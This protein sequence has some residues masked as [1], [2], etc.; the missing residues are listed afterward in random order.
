VSKRD[1]LLPY[2][3]G[4]VL[5][6]SAVLAGGGGVLY[7]VDPDWSSEPN[8]VAAA[9]ALAFGQFAGSVC[10]ADLGISGFNIRFRRR[11]CD[12][13]FHKRRAVIGALAFG[14]FGC[15]SVTAL[16]LSG[17][18]RGEAIAFGMIA[19]VMLGALFGFAASKVFAVVVGVEPPGRP[20]AS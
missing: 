9:A 5:L 4:C 11:P 18:A 13:H 14:F 8:V 15:L 16:W 17:E 3:W 20:P 2:Q 1:T 7:A 6:V 10:F 12:A 19:G